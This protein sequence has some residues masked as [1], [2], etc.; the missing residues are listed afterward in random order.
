MNILVFRAAGNHS[1][2]F[3]KQVFTQVIGYFLCGIRKPG[4]VGLDIK[5]RYVICEQNR[6]ECTHCTWGGISRKTTP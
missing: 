2:I 5:E 3:F 4:A 1:V 6:A